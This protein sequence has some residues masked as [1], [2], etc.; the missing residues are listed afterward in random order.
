MRTVIRGAQVVDGTGAAPSVADIAIENGVVVDL[1]VGLDGDESFDAS[2]LTALPGLIDCHTHVMLSGVDYLK[3]MQQPFS[4]PN[5]LAVR[6]LEETL[7]LGITTVRDAGGADLGVKQAI[8]DGLIRGPRMQISISILGQT[9]GHSDNTYPNGTCVSL[10]PCHPGRPD[11]VV[12]GVEN[13]RLRV[14]ELKRAG[15]DVIKV[16]ASGGV[17]SPRDDPR[18]PQFTFDELATAVEEASTTHTFVMA[19]AQSA[20]GIKNAVRAGIRSIEH[21][22]F[23][24]DEGIEMML[25]NGTY[26]VPTLAAPQAVIDAVNNGAQ[27]PAEVVAKAHAVVDIHRTNVAKAIAAGVKVAMGTDSGVGPHGNNLVE[28]ALMV[29]C[30]LSPLESIK[31]SSLNAAELMGIENELGSIEVGKRADVVLISGGVESLVGL[32]ERVSAVWKDGVQVV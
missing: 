27:L 7:K 31:A 23:L 20:I 1:G 19:H 2:G 32:K 4:Y 11:G 29:E 21:G 18:H 17:L 12:D 10:V 14:R 3:L 26:L 24:D 28:L 6:N 25:A 13:M 22:I 15:A 30:G 9:G 16:C 5:F 8:E